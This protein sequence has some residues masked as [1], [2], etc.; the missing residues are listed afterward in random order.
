MTGKNNDDKSQVIE[1]STNRKLSGL[2]GLVVKWVAIFFTIF[3]MYAVYTGNITHMPRRALF[4]GLGLIILIAKNKFAANTK[5][6]EKIPVYDLIFM[7]LILIATFYVVFNYQEMIARRLHPTPI[8]YFL[9]ISLIVFGLDVARRT[10]GW[11]LPVLALFFLGYTF[12]GQYFPGVWSHAG[13]DPRM[14]IGRMYLG[15]SGFWGM[16]PSISTRIIAIFYI[17]GLVVAV[18]GGGDSFINIALKL[19]GR[20]RGGAAKVATIGSS[21]MGM[22]SG[23]GMANAAATGSLTIPMMKRLGYKSEFTGAVE[24]VASTGGQIMPP[25]MGAGAFLMAE[26]T[27]IP[28]LQIVIAAIIPALLFYIGDFIVI[29]LRARKDGIKPVPDEEIPKWSQAFN[30]EAVLQL[31]IPILLIVFF[32]VQGASVQYAGSRALAWVI[33]VFVVLNRHHLIRDKLKILLQSFEKA[34]YSMAT[35]AALAFVAQ[36]VV[37]LISATGV[38]LKFSQLIISIGGENMVAVLLLA[39]LVCIILGMGMPTTAAYVLSASLVAPALI[40]LGTPTLTAHMFVFYFAIISTITPPVCTGIYTVAQIAEVKWQK[41]VPD[42]IKLGLVG[43]IVPFM[44]IYNS[45]LL[46]Q[47]SVLEITAVFLVKILGIAALGVTTVGYLDVSLNVYLRG[48]FLVG[49]ILTIT[50]GWATNILG[51]IVIVAVFVFYKF[52][53]KKKALNLALKNSKTSVE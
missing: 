21:L 18:T 6:G 45:A 48:A 26:I 44:F 52:N 7:A 42:A 22:I 14:F 46:M 10:M 11:A 33:I 32:L 4:V 40:N 25:I 19:A 49:A 53:L 8:E 28:Y 24:A 50:P 47:G 16:L 5:K 43:F 9:A 37:S 3:Q 12:F 17:L 35:L 30:L 1:K 27:G 41:I 15:D 23:S 31:I 36:I 13:M 2:H 34:G 29:D 51:V 20:A 39:M 38:G